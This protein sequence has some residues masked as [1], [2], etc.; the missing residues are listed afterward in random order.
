MTALAVARSSLATSLTRYSRSWGLWLLLLVAPVGAR[1]MIARDNGAGM[2]VAIGGHLPVMT[3]ATLGVCLGIVVSTLL[4]PVAFIYL[5]ANVTRRQPWQVEEVT[6]AARAQIMFGRFAADAAVLLAMLAALTVAGWVLGWMIVTGPYHIGWIALPLWLVA[7]PALIGLAALR[8]LLDARPL[9]RRGF[10][11]FLFFVLW[12]ASLILPVSVVDRPSS[13]ATN[14]VDYG[15]FVRPLVEGSPDRND[16][17]AIGGS[18]DLKPGRVPLATERGLAAPGYVTSRLAW[19]LLSAAIAAFAG[20]VYAPHRTRARR[21]IGSRLARWLD[22][23]PP[24]PADRGARAARPSAMPLLNLVAAEFRLIG[25]GR[26]FALLA[27]VAAGSGLLADYRHIGSPAALLLLIFALS[28]HAGRS[29]ARGL[30]A[31]TT[32]A[33]LPPVTRRAAF[34]L[35]GTSWALLLALPAAMMQLSLQPVLL[36][37][38]TG[39]AASLVAIGLAALSGSGFA[40]RLVLLIAWYGYF[41]S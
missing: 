4:L 10:G 11:D 22:P 7:A 1:F 34:V 13:L 16:D 15:G 24:A 35:A 25:H 33:M 9:G 29:E 18:N 38:A 6:P 40:A 39:L 32:T 36:A 3:S 2:Q 20:L 37:G 30:R 21:A 5:R 31:L 26:L 17:F 12:M 41:S 27:L 19:I 23:A 28:A 14:F 8:V